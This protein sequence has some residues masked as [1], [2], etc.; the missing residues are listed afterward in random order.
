[1]RSRT[2]NAV[3][4]QMGEPPK[5]LREWEYLFG[6]LIKDW[7]S[8]LAGRGLDPRRWQKSFLDWIN[9]LCVSLNALIMLKCKC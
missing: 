7:L 8:R 4:Y 1:M 3:T 9:F 6:R 2:C 5:T